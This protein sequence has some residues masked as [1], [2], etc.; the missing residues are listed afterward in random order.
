[1]VLKREIRLGNGR[2]FYVKNEKK[3]ERVIFK[4]YSDTCIVKR[5]VNK[6]YFIIYCIC[7]CKDCISLCKCDN[8]CK[9]IQFTISRND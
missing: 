7:I 4:M 2:K 6:L 1:M 3:M 9:Y 5:A 8:Y